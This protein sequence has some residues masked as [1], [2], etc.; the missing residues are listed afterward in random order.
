MDRA[1][2]FSDRISGQDSKSDGFPGKGFD[3]DRIILWLLG[4]LGLSLGRG[5]VVGYLGVGGLV[6]GVD[7]VGDIKWGENIFGFVALEYLSAA[8]LNGWVSN[9]H[10]LP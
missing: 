9:G 4:R 6:G 8:R 5:G 3:F 7:L 2:D 10:Q 1:L